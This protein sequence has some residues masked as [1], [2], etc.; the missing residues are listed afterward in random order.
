MITIPE[1][2][3]ARWIIFMIDMLIC[4]FSLI[5][6]YLIR[7]DFTAFPLSEEWPILR[8]SWPFFL[9]IRGVTFYFGRTYAGIVRYTST[10]DA[11]RIFLTVTLGSAIFGLL[12]PVWYLSFDAYFLPISIIVMDYLLTVF[13]M[14]TFRM[15]VKLIYSEQVNPSS[16]RSH[17]LIYGAGEMGLITKRTLDRDAASKYKVVAFIDDNEKKGGKFLEGVPIYSSEKLLHL[18]RNNHIRELVVAMLNPEQDHLDKVVDICLANE[19]EVLNVPPVQSWINGELSFKQIRKVKIE[20][21]L[22]RKPIKLDEKN[23]HEKMA[24]KIILVTGA[25]GSIGSEIVRQL[26]KFQPE[27]IVMLDQAESALYDFDMELRS[28][29]KDDLCETVIGDITTRE[30]MERVFAHFRPQVVFHAAAYKHVP[31]MEENPSEAIR[32]NV[33]GTKNLVD[34]SLQY[35][36]ERFVM[37]STDKAVNPTNVMGASK[38]VAEIYAQSCNGKGS[39]KFITTRFGNVLGS[40]GS[41]IPLFR[42]QI[43]A[44]GP[45]TVTHPEVTRYFMTIP[46]ACQLV[47]EA[48]SMGEGGEIFVFDMGKSIKIVDLAKNMIKLSGLEPEKDIKIKFVGLRPGE[49]LYEE[50]LSDKENTMPTHHHQIMVAKVRTYDFEEVQQNVM[51]LIALFNTQNNTEIVTK[52]KAIVPE[53]VSNN[54]EFEALDKK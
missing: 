48:G 20:D 3:T 52:L 39:T 51:Q 33:E 8:L 47:L 49:K 15:V 35:Q 42:K 4:V 28:R 12:M 2:N 53:Y 36:V 44:G 13:L 25:A 27:K 26:T 54:S 46:E 41:V 31:L 17:I 45:I 24:G 19:I 34:L 50:V 9:L 23:I 21:L 43:E 37:I 11:K 6:A 10:Q 7:F 30:R 5:L 14:I 32:T 1:R 29:Q 40:N 38:R 16:E 22:G 18:I